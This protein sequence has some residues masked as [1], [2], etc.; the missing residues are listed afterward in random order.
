MR[1]LIRDRDSRGEEGLQ[2]QAACRHLP[3]LMSCGLAGVPPCAGTREAEEMLLLRFN[4]SVCNRLCD[5]MG[6]S[7]SALGRQ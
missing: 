5:R 1:S 6:K 7:R 2:L 4:F 3:F